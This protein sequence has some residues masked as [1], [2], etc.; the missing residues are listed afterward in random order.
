MQKFQNFPE[1]PAGDPRD[2][3]TGSRFSQDFPRKSNKAKVLG[4]LSGGATVESCK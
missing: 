3:A 4:V 2:F 1:F